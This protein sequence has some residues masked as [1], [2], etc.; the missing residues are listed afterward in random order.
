M[1]KIKDFLN[2]YKGILLAIMM[3]LLLICP[4]FISGMAL[5]VLSTIFIYCI[6]AIGNMVITG[7]TGMLNMGQAA[8]YGVGAYTSAILSTTIG[9][10]FIVCFFAAGLLTGLFGMMI[11]IPCLRV[12]TDF[13]SLITIA[14]ANIFTAILLNWTS[15]TRGPMGIPAIPKASIFG[16]T[17]YS[18]VQYYYLLLFFTVFFYVVISNLMNSKVGRMFEATRD[19]EVGARSIGINVKNIKVVSFTIGTS[20]AG[21]AGSLM[22]H[23]IGFVGPSNFTFDESL[24]IMQMCIIGGLGSLP[25]AVLGAAFFVIMPEIIRPLAVYRLGIGGLIM[26][27]SMLF[28]PQGFLGSPAFAGKGG[29]QEKLRSYFL[30]HSKHKLVENG[31]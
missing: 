11:A 12:R 9:L 23:Y 31:R 30:G 27:L 28:R 17:F 16:Y 6:L 10:P 15:L 1:I 5:R 13:L 8:F 21:F 25:G 19:D 3:L 7:Y 29:F 2:K 26:T 14:F 22:V 20:L 24:L 18:S 4:L